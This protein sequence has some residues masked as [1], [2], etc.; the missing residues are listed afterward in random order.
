MDD[1]LLRKETISLNVKNNTNLPQNANMLGGTQDP[2]GV[3]P[4]TLYQWDLTG[5]S[6]YGNVSVSIVISSTSNPTPVVY[7]VPV[8]GYNINAVLGALNSLGLGIFQVSGNIIYVSNDYYIYGALSVLSTAFVSTWNTSNTTGG[9]SGA[10]Q[11]QLPLNSGGTYNFTIFWGDGTSDVIT[12]WNQPETLHTYASAGTYSVGIIG[13]ITEWSFGNAVVTDSEKLLS[14]SSWGTLQFG[15]SAD[16][17][18]YQCFNLDLSAVTDVPDLSASLNFNNAFDD[19][20]SLTS[21]NRSNEWDTSNINTMV[22]TFA[23][24]LTSILT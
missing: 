23:C 19:C 11:I 22:A 14:I 16:L 21:I 17:S 18:F 6:Y 24:V 13:T 8:N 3:P 4:H 1:N 15:V 10:N 12:S 9:S 7:T 5:E 20:T 2:L